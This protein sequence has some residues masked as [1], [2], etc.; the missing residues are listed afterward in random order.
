MMKKIDAERAAKGFL[1][2]IEEDGW[3]MPDQ[4]K[5]GYVVFHSGNDK[6]T[7]P[8]Y[9]SSCRTVF[10]PSIDVAE[11]FHTPGEALDVMTNLL[12]EISEHAVCRKYFG[13][14]KISLDVIARAS[15]F[16]RQEVK[17]SIRCDGLAERLGNDDGLVETLLLDGFQG[18][19]SDVFAVPGDKTVRIRCGN[20]NHA[21]YEVDCECGNHVEWI[22]HLKEKEW[23]SG[24]LRR[25]GNEYVRHFC[26][27]WGR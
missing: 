7:V 11:V 3:S 22:E 6:G 14:G 1:D 9:M 18:L 20:G 26:G 16:V 12:G 21:L 15:D 27:K 23:Y 19:R 17:D 25:A 8:F 4:V 5:V 13:I 2:G 24:E 10:S